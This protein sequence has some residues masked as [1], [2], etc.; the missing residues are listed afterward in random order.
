MKNLLLTAILIGSLNAACIDVMTPPLK[1][2][3]TMRL[4]E[5]DLGT[6][7]GSLPFN[8]DFNWNCLTKESVERSLA[9]LTDSSIYGMLGTWRDS[10]ILGILSSNILILLSRDIS[11][12]GFNEKKKHM[13]EIIWNLNRLWQQIPMF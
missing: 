6:T 5:Q 10:R 13:K 7:C 3:C 1:T 11:L 12:F 8:S 2:H 9:R 4:L